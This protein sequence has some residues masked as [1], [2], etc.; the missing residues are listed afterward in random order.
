MTLAIYFGKRFL[1]SLLLMTMGVGILYLASE[2]EWHLRS[3]RDL[4]LPTAAILGLSLLKLASSLYG[5]LP[6]I[7]GLAA[8]ATSIRL[9]TTSEI[10]V[11]RA[12]GLS[13]LGALL[14]PAAVAAGVGV[15][16]LLI[17]NPFISE[18]SKQYRLLTESL[19]A[20]GA[21]VVLNESAIFW[22]RQESDSGHAVIQ[23]S[24]VSEGSRFE[25]LTVFEFNK[26]GSITV[27]RVAE[28]GILDDGHWSLYNVKSWYLEDATQNPEDSAVY[29]EELMVP[30]S[31]TIEEIGRSFD[32]PN[33]VPFWAIPKLAI[34]LEQAGF[35]SLLYRVHL[36]R[37][38]AKPVLL[39]AMAL[40]GAGFT[41]RFSR[42]R[43]LD[44]M[45]L[46]A[47]VA[48]LAVYFLQDFSA[49]LGQTGELP[50]YGAVWAPPVSALFLSVSLLLFAEEF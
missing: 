2:F 42:F 49:V 40:I 35:S 25:E 38:I 50:I 27:R 30:T 12:A 29:S 3:F 16:A 24:Q 43:R 46:T 22:L 4:E 6:I 5:I 33:E 21:Q 37:E 34:R 31:L 36:Q 20:R 44:V 7:V 8:L 13:A 14:S 47:V 48:V 17:L 1:A 9:S 28:S 10:V 11:A 23:A 41:L 18:T 39:A 26:E 32:S 45:A 15:L 19:R